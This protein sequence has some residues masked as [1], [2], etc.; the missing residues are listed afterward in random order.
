MAFGLNRVELIGRLGADVTV[1]QL[2]SGGRVANLSIATDESY[3]NRQTGDKV[4]KTEWHRVVTFQDGLIDM[5]VKHAVKGRLV[6][7][8]G[9]L[10]TRRWSKPDEDGDRVLDRDPARPRRTGAVPR[11]AER[12]RRP[13]AGRSGHGRRHRRRA[14]FRRARGSGRRNSVLGSAPLRILPPDLGTGASAS[15]PFFAAGPERGPFGRRARAMRGAPALRRRPEAEA[16]RY[17]ASRTDWK[18][19][20]MQPEPSPAA[21]IAAA[22]GLQAEAV[23]R[24]YLPQGRK[25]GRYWVAGDLDGAR[26]RSLFVRLRGPGV[27]GKWTDAATGQ[28]GDLLDLIRHRTRAPSLRAALDEARA[29][30][31]LEPA[32]DHDP[33][34]VP[35]MGSSSDY[36]STEAARRLWRQCRAIGG[37]HAE[38]YLHARGLSQCRFAALRFHPELRYREGSSVRRFPALVAAVTGNDGAIIGVQRTWLDPRRAAKAGVTTPRRAL[39]RI[40]GHAVRF[41]AIPADGLASL[42]V[43]EGIETVLSLITAVPEIGAAA[44]LSAGSLGAFAPPPGIARLVIARDNDEDGALA[45]ER[46]ARRCARAG[47][48]ATVIVPVGND[49]NDDLVAFGADGLGARLGPFLRSNTAAP[50]SRR[51]G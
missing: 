15:V 42:V 29:F 51:R 41:G 38:R 23:C 22:L 39:G 10:Q 31:A 36:D 27:P 34:A 32:P 19:S 5:F 47:I 9:K 14:G 28:H 44:A 46:L 16:G 12:Q 50:G 7:I 43:G 33:G 25:L 37:T 26:G 20:R 40:F 8:D 4:D 30:L 18:E 6:Y 3:I 11:Q 45:A 35:A 1:N 13:G 2:M 49:F 21:G 48:A 17:R 24:R